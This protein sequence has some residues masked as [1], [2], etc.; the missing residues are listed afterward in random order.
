MLRLVFL[1]QFLKPESK[2]LLGAVDI[3]RPLFGNNLQIE[4]LLLLLDPDRLAPKASSVD[5]TSSLSRSWLP[6][7]SG[8]YRSDSF[9]TW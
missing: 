1:V 5:F 8:L 9:S 3:D 4:I 2:G 7:V 6:S